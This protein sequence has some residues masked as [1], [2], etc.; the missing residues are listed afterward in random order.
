MLFLGGADATTLEYISKQ[1]GKETIRSVN[2][3]R[4]FGKQGSYSSSFN[5][6][7]REL[8]T[9]DELRV[10][11]N[12]NCI[13]FIRGLH[14]FF[15]TKFKLE[16]H[17]NFR[18]SGDGNKK[19]LFDI[20]K[21]VSTVPNYAAKQEPNRAVKLYKEAQIAD[22]RSAERQHRYYNRPV[23]THTSRGT[24]TM[25]SVPLTEVIPHYGVPADQLTPEQ[26]AM[27]NAAVDNYEVESVYIPPKEAV[28]EAYAEKVL[29]CIDVQHELF[30]DFYSDDSSQG[31]PPASEP[32]ETPEP[33]EEPT[34]SDTIELEFGDE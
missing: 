15:G 18:F 14:P 23:A 11:D 2:N 19:L 20:K 33:P 3:S 22:T 17:P 32:V 4:S 30:Q 26:L 31:A 16:D 24:P 27:R 34:G 10:M 1:L 21:N 6:T 25:Q 8:L 13:L 28:Q 5:K 12:N 7:G 9:P 29:E